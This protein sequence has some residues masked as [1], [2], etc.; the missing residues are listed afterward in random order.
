MRGRRG[1]RGRAPHTSGCSSVGAGRRLPVQ[2]RP[3]P[4]LFSDWCILPPISREGVASSRPGRKPRAVVSSWR[5]RACAL[6]WEG[7]GAVS[8]DLPPSQAGATLGNL[9]QDREARAL[10]SEASYPGM[11]TNLGKMPRWWCICPCFV[12]MGKL[13]IRG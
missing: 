1:R 2:P 5:R 7:L 9:S 10:P 11:V 4:R 8:P 3:L 13:N 12:L 6:G